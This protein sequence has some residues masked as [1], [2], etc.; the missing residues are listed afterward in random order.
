MGGMSIGAWLFLSFLLF[1]TRYVRYFMAI[2]CMFFMS[3]SK[4]SSDCLCMAPR[5]EVVMVTRGL[6]FHPVVFNV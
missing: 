1:R 6:T 4:A 3:F 2:W 5:S